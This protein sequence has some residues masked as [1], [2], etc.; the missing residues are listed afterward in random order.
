MDGT[1]VRSMSKLYICG[2]RN[3][4]FHLSPLSQSEIM[5]QPAETPFSLDLALLS[6]RQKDHT[7]LDTPEFSSGS[8]WGNACSGYRYLC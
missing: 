5:E 6:K 3:L 4:C 1:E 7:M 2:N 8:I